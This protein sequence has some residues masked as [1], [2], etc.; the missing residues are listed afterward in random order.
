MVISPQK[1][2]RQHSKRTRWRGALSEDKQRLKA[3]VALDNR[4][5]SIIKLLL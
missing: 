5:Q 4:C 2:V 1:Q 3:G